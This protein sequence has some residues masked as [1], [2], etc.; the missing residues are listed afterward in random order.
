MS[1]HV[2]YI[3]Y[4]TDTGRPKYYILCD[5]HTATPSDSVYKQQRVRL[6]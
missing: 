4:N 2:L 5:L 6:L 3:H 1:I